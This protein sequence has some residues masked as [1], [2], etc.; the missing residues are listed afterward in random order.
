MKARTVM[1]LLVGCTFAAMILGDKLEGDGYSRLLGIYDSLKPVSRYVRVVD[2]DGKPLAGVRF[3]VRVLSSG[4]LLGVRGGDWTE[5]CETDGRG[6]WSK[7]FSKAYSLSLDTRSFRKD[8]YVYD[9]D[10]NRPRMYLEFLAACRR[11]TPC[12]VVMNRAQEKSYLVIPDRIDTEKI[13]DLKSGGECVTGRV[14]LLKLTAERGVLANPLNGAVRRGH[15]AIRPY[16]DLFVS[17]RYDEEAG[18]WRVAFWTT[19]ANCGVVATARRRYEAPE[20]GYLPR[21]EVSQEEYL[22]PSF[23][24]YLRTRE[25]RVY[26]MVV[27]AGLEL[28]VPRE[29]RSG[30]EGRRRFR[31]LLREVRINPYGTREMELDERGCNFYLEGPVKFRA[32]HDLLLSGRHPSKPD[33]ERLFPLAVRKAVLR[34]RR[35][36]LDRSRAGAVENAS[37]EA[38]R[39]LAH[40]PEVERDKGIREARE[41]AERDY[42][43]RRSELEREFRDV[44]QEI[45]DILRKDGK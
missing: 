21:A 33:L 40:S 13:I 9:K 5:H 17:A 29:T 11:E 43:K 44:N 16:D 32:L 41:A 19:N 20:D 3:D 22:S 35:N 34:R 28:Q 31:F 36:D 2:E 24:L 15:V 23:T 25:P 4:F 45:I 8:G 6:E 42:F 38:A 12:L 1:L 37:L 18:G 14:D 30:P 7:T 10:M 27:P 39:R 26:A